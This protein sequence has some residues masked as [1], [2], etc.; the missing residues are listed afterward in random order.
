ML[1][2]HKEIAISLG[3]S[4]DNIIVPDNG[5]I[6]EIIDNGQKIMVFLS[7]MNKI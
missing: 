1:V 6:I 2:K 5:S 3:M 7:E 4:P